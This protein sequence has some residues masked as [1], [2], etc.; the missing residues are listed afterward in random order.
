MLRWLYAN[1]P[2]A[3]RMSEVKYGVWQVWMSPIG[4]LFTMRFNKSN[5][6][7]WLL[8]NQ[9]ALRILESCDAELLGDL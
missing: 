7:E 4:E 3:A 1:P 6:I 8:T 2:P 9:M 5:S